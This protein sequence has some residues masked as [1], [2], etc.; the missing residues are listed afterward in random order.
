M[1]IMMMND[2]QMGNVC[3]CVDVLEG[4]KPS[5]YNG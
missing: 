3:G 2:R 5:V 1:V 4:D